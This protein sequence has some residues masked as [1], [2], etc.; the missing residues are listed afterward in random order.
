MKK[1]NSIFLRT[2]FT[3]GIFFASGMAI[4]GYFNEDSFLIWK[5]IIHFVL[6]GTV[7]GFLARKKHIQKERETGASQEQNDE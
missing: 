5:F 6:F 1:E 4:F 3:A 2:F 7:M